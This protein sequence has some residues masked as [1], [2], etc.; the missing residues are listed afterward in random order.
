MK[1]SL[2]FILNRTLL[3]HTKEIYNRISHAKTILPKRPIPSPK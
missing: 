2:F 3:L 1:I